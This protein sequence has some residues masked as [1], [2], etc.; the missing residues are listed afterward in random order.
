MISHIHLR[1]AKPA[2]LKFMYEVVEQTMRPTVERTFLIWHKTE[3][4]AELHEFANH[5][6]TKIVKIDDQDCG[7]FYVEE[8]KL[9]YWIQWVFILPEFQGNGVGKRLLVDVLLRAHRRGLP[10]RLRVHRSSSA[11]TFYE[12]LGFSV[13]DQTDKFLYMQCEKQNSV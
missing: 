3:M 9:E 12:L 6:I 13:Y 7:L 1:Q 2:D 4:L 8:R 5:P 10:V 11:K